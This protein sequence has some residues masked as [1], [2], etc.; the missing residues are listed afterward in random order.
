MSRGMFRK[1]LLVTFVAR[2]WR[3]RGERRIFRGMFGKILL[4]I[5]VVVGL[6]VAN[7]HH[8]FAHLNGGAKPIASAVI[9][10]VLWPLLLLGLKLHIK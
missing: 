5:Y 8:Y 7:S 6:I 2:H 4:A 9:A 10:V 1:A 3:R